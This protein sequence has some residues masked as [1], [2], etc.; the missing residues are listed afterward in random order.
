MHRANI[1]GSCL[2]AEGL[3]ASYRYTA[4]DA[5]VL[6]RYRG[7]VAVAICRDA[8]AHVFAA[9]HGP[10][11]V[12]LAFA[13]HATPHFSNQARPI[14]SLHRHHTINL[15]AISRRKKSIVRTF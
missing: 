9:A 1:L 11:C 14:F 15:A 7:P 4:T 12:T 8:T 13:V 10:G 6:V 2:P 5:D 3:T